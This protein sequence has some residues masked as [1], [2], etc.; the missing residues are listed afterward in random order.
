MRKGPGTAPRRRRAETLRAPAGSG[1]IPAE[2]RR[3]VW[4]RDHGCCQ[5]KLANGE[6]CGSGYRAQY[7]HIHPAGKGGETTIANVRLLCQRHNLLAARLA[8]GER[9]MRRYGRTRAQTGA[10]PG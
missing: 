9:L 7:D 10:P 3:A 2:I 5:W 1:R 4:E 8:Y 6:R